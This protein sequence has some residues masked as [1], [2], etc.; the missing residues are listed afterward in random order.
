MEH[1]TTGRHHRS[2]SVHAK[3]LI[4]RRPRRT[5]RAGPAPPR[6]DEPPDADEAERPSETDPSPHPPTPHR[7]P[8]YTGV[9]L[10]KVICLGL[11]ALALCVAIGIGSM[12]SHQNASGPRSARPDLG[13]TG[14]RALLPDLLN[15]AV[16]GRGVHNAPGLSERETRATGVIE[17]TGGP[18]LTDAPVSTTSITDAPVVTVDPSPSKLALVLR[19]YDLIQKSPDRAF[20]LLDATALGT[21]LAEF[22]R[23]W[24]SVTD[25]HVLEVREQDDGVLA[26]VRM[27]LPD[28]TYLRIQQLLKITDTLP[29]RIVGAQ[30]RSASRG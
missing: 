1:P 9:H 22:V 13:I 24:A 18:V 12:I 7:R 8:H 17:N 19:Y 21:D 23:S 25:V 27:R 10:A 15:S 30:I 26:S 6:D 11:S 14:E 16:P 20:S 28:G 2:G 29:Q 5:G 3:D 4:S